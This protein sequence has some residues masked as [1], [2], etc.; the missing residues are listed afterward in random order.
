MSNLV[1]IIIDTDTYAINKCVFLLSFLFGNAAP[2][3]E[4]SSE[5]HK[6][7]SSAKFGM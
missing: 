7:G 4:K 6:R 3:L 2:F 1:H 5:S